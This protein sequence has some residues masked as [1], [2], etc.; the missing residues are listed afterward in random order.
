M[1]TDARISV[2]LKDHPKMKK[3]IRRLGPGAGLAIIW[4]FLWSAQNRS[5]GDLAGMTDEDIELACDWSGEA[6]AFV[7]EAADVKFLDGEEGDRRIHDWAE[8]NPWAAGA[9]MRSAKARWNSVKGH[10]G[11]AEAD[12]QV[13]EYAAVRRA[14]SS[15]SSSKTGASSSKKD[16]GSTADTELPAVLGSDR[17]NTPSPSPSPFPSPSPSPNEEHPNGCLSASQPTGD[18]PR[19]DGIP[20]AGDPPKAKAGV[21]PCPYDTLI[22]AYHELCP[23]MP[24]VRPGLFKTG[25]RGDAMLARWKF[26]LTERAEVGDKAGQR[27]AT[28]VDEGVAWFRQFFEFVNGSSFLRGEHGGRPWSADLGWLLTLGNFEKVLE[29]KYHNEAQEVDYA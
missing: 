2:G 23:T 13:P 8:H 11:E 5:N 29:G 24:R 7:R 18:Q 1:A 15:A 20:D 22:D 10:H 6:G 26:V 16:A 19:L 21:P 9:G 28:N 12:R 17:S 27:M 25:K 14:G 4:L 3:L